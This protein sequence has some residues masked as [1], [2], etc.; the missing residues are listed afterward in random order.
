LRENSS[1]LTLPIFAGV[2]DGARTDVPSH[3][4]PTN[5]AA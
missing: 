1:T 3:A 4:Q 5:P 2:C